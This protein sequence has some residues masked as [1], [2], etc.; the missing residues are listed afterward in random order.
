MRIGGTCIIGFD[1]AWTDNIK[2]QGAVC[3]LVIA[4]DGT[5]SFQPPRHA[6]FDQAL[7]FIEAEGRACDTC[8]VALDQPTIVPNETGSRPVDKVAAALAR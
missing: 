3:A 5:V 2:A 8:L 7:A 1:S 4:S 6:T